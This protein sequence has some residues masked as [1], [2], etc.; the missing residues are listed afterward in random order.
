MKTLLEAVNSMLSTINEQPL[1][2]DVDIDNSLEATIAVDMLNKVKRE[3]LSEGWDANT[4]E[5]WEFSPD[6]EGIIGIPEN[7]LEITS[8]DGKSIMRDWR[9]YNKRDK[10]FIYDSPVL[11]NVKWDLD[12]E[13]L[14]YSLAY[15]ITMVASRQFQ[16]ELIGDTTVDRSLER[17][18]ATARINAVGNNDFTEQ[19][20]MLDT[21][22][23]QFRRSH[24]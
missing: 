20:N 16:M 10:T 4:D 3:I 21:M 8:L 11:C 5:S 14:T 22:S 18:E 15:Y 12:F 13:D 19:S 23:Y 1:E 17:K 6:S 9:L 24:F 2:D 7:V